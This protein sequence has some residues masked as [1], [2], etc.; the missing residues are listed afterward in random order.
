MASPRAVRLF[1]KGR[2]QAMRIPRDLAAAIGLS[3]SPCLRRVTRLESAG[4]ITGYGAHLDAV[5]LG[6]KV[7]AL[8]NVTLDRQAKSSVEKFEK[9]IS[10][11]PEVVDLYLIADHGAEFGGAEEEGIEACFAEA[12]GAADVGEEDLGFVWGH[13]WRAWS[14]AVVLNEGADVESSL[15]GHGSL[16]AS[17]EGDSLVDHHFVE[18]AVEDDL[19]EDRASGSLGEEW[20]KG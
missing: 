3:E 6:L 12:A 2:N 11:I 5:G 1:K 13:G 16:L 15:A 8:V 10:D 14:G 7:T 17:V 19:L 18:P 4:L 20:A 9:A